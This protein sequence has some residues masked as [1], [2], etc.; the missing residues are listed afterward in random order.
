[1]SASSE[2]RPQNLKA[3]ST[4]PGAAQFKSTQNRNTR[5][6][7]HLHWNSRININTCKTQKAILDINQEWNSDFGPDKDRKKKTLG[8]DFNKSA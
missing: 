5:Q 7:M 3:S 2:G 4:R 8:K 6:T 1:M